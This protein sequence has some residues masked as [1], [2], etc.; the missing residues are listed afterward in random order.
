MSDTQNQ[1]ISQFTFEQVEQRLQTIKFD[2][3]ADH[4]LN[5]EGN[6]VQ[7]T[8]T[9]GSQYD[10]TDIKN[11][12]G[13]L[14]D[15]TTVEQNS[16]VG[17][18]NELDADKVDKTEL[19]NKANS[20]DVYLKTETYSRDEVDAYLLDKADKTELDAYTTTDD[21]NLLLAEKADKTDLDDLATETFVQEKINE[22]ALAGQPVDLSIYI[23]KDTVGELTDLATTEQDTIVEAINEVKTLADGKAN[24]GTTLAEYGIADAYTKDEADA[25]IQTKVAEAISNA[26]HLKREIVTQIPTAD[27][28]EENTVYMF[29]V[30]TAK[31]SDLYQEW[32]LIDGDVVLIGDTSVDLSNYQEKITGAKGQYVGFNDAG[33]TVAVNLELNKEPYG[34]VDGWLPEGSV[35][36]FR[37]KEIRILCPATTQWVKTGGG[38]TDK[39]YIGIKAYAP[40]ETVMKFKEDWGHPIGDPTMWEL[41]DVDAG[42]GVDPDG[43]R[44]SVFWVTA[45]TQSPDGTWVYTGKD[46]A[47]G[48]FKGKD[49][50]VE[51]YTA[52]DKLVASDHIRINFSNEA[53]HSSVLPFYSGELG[54][55]DAYDDSELIE[56]VERIEESLDDKQDKYSTVTNGERTLVQDDLYDDTPVQGVDFTITD[57][58]CT[59]SQNITPTLFKD[60]KAQV[61]FGNL[62][63]IDFEVQR[64]TYW[65][66]LEREV[67]TETLVALGFGGSFTGKVV[68]LVNNTVG[69]TV[70]D[71]PVEKLNKT[72]AHGDRVRIYRNVDGSVTLYHKTKNEDTFIKWFD[73]KAH[74]VYEEKVLGFACGIGQPET[75]GHFY[76]NLTTLFTSMKLQEE[77]P[78]PNYQVSDIRIAALETK[79]DKTSDEMAT[80][81][82]KKQD[83]LTGKEGQIIRID[84][85][86]EAVAET[87]YNKPKYEVWMDWLPNGSVVDYRE[88]EIRIC[89]PHDATWV[90]EGGGDAD[91][92]YVG[93][94]AYAPSENVAKFKEDWGLPIKDDTMWDLTDIDAGTGEDVDGR[95]YS[96]FW[97]A[98][99]TLNADDGTW[100]Y[101]GKD[102]TEKDFKGKDY[103]VEWYDANNTLVASDCIRIN[104]SNENCHGSVLPFYSGQLGGGTGNNIREITQSDYNLL[105]PDEQNN[106]TAYFVSDAP[107]NVVT[108]DNGLDKTSDNPISNKAV[109]TKFEE[110]EQGGLN[111]QITL[112]DEPLQDS[113]NAVKSGGVFNA[114]ENKQDKIIGTPNQIVGIGTDGTPISIDGSL[115]EKIEYTPSTADGGNNV[116]KIT[117]TDGSVQ[118]FNIK[119]G[120]KGSTGAT[121]ATGATGSIAKTTFTAPSTDIASNYLA[122]DTYDSTKNILVFIDG[123]VCTSVRVESFISNYSTNHKWGILFTGGSGSSVKKWC[124]SYNS[125][126]YNSKRITYCYI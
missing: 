78:Y 109:A 102:S 47:E 105:T 14:T 110:L 33:E 53:C 114:L 63:M 101:T 120:S 73:T 8:T 60:T 38:D 91:K 108:V 107:S 100:T 89:C 123:L 4:F 65:L 35:V 56:R 98:A 103:A 48:N 74:N 70:E 22:A 77:T 49:Y 115:I 93:I 125:G 54:G 32:M 12:I 68:K 95:K 17:A 31:G 28:A 30:G 44:Y 82:E 7:V 11:S 9:G 34:I 24:V 2:Q 117:L 59:L 29:K 106:G 64:S 3:P 75:A 97:V 116:L 16:L 62:S 87:D 45:A 43:R 5:G 50:A 51:W 13:T 79:Q 83:T 86:G 112:D 67:A 124:L 119:N 81:L 122:L 1:K 94:K 27:V 55:G 58:T 10:D 88:K 19:D 37:E 99:A 20:A 90:K 92:C 15:L 52:D 84:E 72:F 61:I 80:E 6:Y 40:N 21:M 121:G 69:D 57:G 66:V 113:E 41:T 96:I 46:S 42:T 85:N 104:F 18:I 118:T 71:E 111:A 126:A 39:C 23:T 36:D 26:N 25:E 76:T